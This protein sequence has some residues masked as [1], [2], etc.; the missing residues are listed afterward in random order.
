MR[1][2]ILLCPRAGVLLDQ[3]VQGGGDATGRL[4][5]TPKGACKEDPEGRDIRGKYRIIITP[6]LLKVKL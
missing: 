6:S 5:V 3:V 2:Q 1:L 4:G